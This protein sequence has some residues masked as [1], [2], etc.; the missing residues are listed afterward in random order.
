M[1]GARCMRSRSLSYDS[2]FYTPR[3]T[4]YLIENGFWCSLLQ[5]VAPFQS[6]IELHGD[7]VTIAVFWELV[8]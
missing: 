8:K 4:S 5:A 7:D 3:A 1:L 6:A 2:V